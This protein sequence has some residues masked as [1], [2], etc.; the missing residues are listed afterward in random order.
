MA[1]MAQPLRQETAP[2]TVAGRFYL[3]QVATCAVAAAS[4]ALANQRETWLRAEAAWQALADREIRVTNA[5]ILRETARS[6]G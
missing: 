1:I 4:A 5:R 2:L 3:E 6:V